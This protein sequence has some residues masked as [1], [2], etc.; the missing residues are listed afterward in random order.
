MQDNVA[1]EVFMS[2]YFVENRGAL[3]EHD[4]YGNVKVEHTL[5]WKNNSVAFEPLC[6]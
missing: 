2:E 6:V 5:F 1:R 4:V 3:D